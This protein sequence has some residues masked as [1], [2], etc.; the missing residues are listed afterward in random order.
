MISNK[1]GI[2]TENKNFKEKV[3][4]RE[5]EES[6]SISWFWLLLMTTI[7]ALGYWVYRKRKRK[8]MTKNAPNTEGSLDVKTMNEKASN[9]LDDLRNQEKDALKK[10]EEKK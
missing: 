10:E 2:E 5:R 6:S 1:I 9:W 8:K 3:S 7:L 4:Y